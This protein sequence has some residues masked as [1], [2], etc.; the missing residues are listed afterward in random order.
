MGLWLGHGYG[1]NFSPYGFR[2]DGQRQ[3]IALLD[4]TFTDGT[5]RRLT[6]DPSWKWSLGPITADDLY[7]GESYDAREERDGWDESGFDDRS[8]RSVSTVDAPRGALR[9]NTMPPVRVVD[10]LRPRKVTEIRPGTYVYDFGQNIAGWARLRCRGCGRYTHHH[11]YRRG[12]QRRRHA[13]YRHQ[14]GCRG[15]R[16]LH[17]RGDGPSREL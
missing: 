10:T 13:G 5:R 8:W 6:T 15:D 17:P 16:H 14:S 12:A 9:S 7:D 4:V 1:E 2:W 11:A 3:A